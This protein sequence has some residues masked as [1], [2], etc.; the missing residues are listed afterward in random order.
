MVRAPHSPVSAHLIPH[1]LQ[2][3][4][5]HFDLYQ[6]TQ[7]FSHYI[8]LTGT[9][10]KGTVFK[11]AQKVEVEK[12]PGHPSDEHSPDDSEYGASAAHHSQLID[13][14]QLFSLQFFPSP[15]LLKDLFILK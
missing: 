6:M 13:F 5:G 2:N 9:L 3:L 11:K 14:Q 7:C 8:I 1:L 12:T 4:K 10:R 15:F